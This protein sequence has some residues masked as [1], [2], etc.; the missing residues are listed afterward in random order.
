MWWE[1]RED[2]DEGHRVQEG[3]SKNNRPDKPQ[4]QLRPQLHDY[5]H[6]FLQPFQFSQKQDYNSPLRPD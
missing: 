5:Q 3:T 4:Q 2:G 6:S 1:D